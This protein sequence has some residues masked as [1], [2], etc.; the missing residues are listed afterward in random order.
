MAFPKPVI[1]HGSCALIGYMK[2]LL[3]VC[4]NV[5]SQ[6][7]GPTPQYSYAPEVSHLVAIALLPIKVVDTLHFQLE[8]RDCSKSIPAILSMF[9]PA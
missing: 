3:H 1:D 7:I 8:V 4:K 5:G 6:A 9:Q 2:N